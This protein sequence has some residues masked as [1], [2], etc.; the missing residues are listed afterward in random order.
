IVMKIETEPF[1]YAP[2]QPEQDA[3]RVS[4]WLDGALIGESALLTTENVEYVRRKRPWWQRWWD[5]L[6]QWL[7]VGD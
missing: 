4:F 2:V 3:G 6:L 5:T 7:G 1:L